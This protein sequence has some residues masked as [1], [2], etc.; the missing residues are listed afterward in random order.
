ME[1]DI[2]NLGVGES[3]PSQFPEIIPQRESFTPPK[4]EVALMGMTLPPFVPFG[5]HVAD[6]ENPDYP[7][8]WA[9]TDTKPQWIFW[10]GGI[11]QSRGRRDSPCP[12]SG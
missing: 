4:T 8:G 3:G 12:S 9:G 7:F 2:F 6:L 10:Y 5:P 1:E 11:C